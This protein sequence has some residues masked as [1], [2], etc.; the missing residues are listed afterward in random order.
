[1]LLCL[2]RWWEAE[3]ILHSLRVAAEKQKRH[4]SLLKIVLLEALVHQARGEREQACA[5]LMEALLLGEAG[6]Y[7][8]VFLDEIKIFTKEA[9]P[10]RRTGHPS[11]GETSLVGVLPLLMQLRETW[12]DEDA[13]DCQKVSIHY[14]DRLISLFEQQA[15]NNSQH[16][17]I[18]TLLTPLS[19]REL[20]VL[21]LIK[22]GKSNHEVAQQLVITVSTVKSHLNTIYSKLQVKS[23]TQAIMRASALKLV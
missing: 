11:K 6:E 17:S 18:H 15:T 19:K 20:E 3:P 4:G 16:G 23:R 10:S 1:M 5:A 2:G 22:A 8:R 7:I 9:P 14:L 21:Q 12:Y 13:S